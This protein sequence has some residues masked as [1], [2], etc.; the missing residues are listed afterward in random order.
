MSPSFEESTVWLIAADMISHEMRN[1]LNAM[2]Q[3]AEEASQSIKPY[4]DSD[5][6]RMPRDVAQENLDAVETI[7]FCGKH[8]KQIIDDVLTISKL[9]ANLLNLCPTATDPSAVAYNALQIYGS[10]MRSSGIRSMVTYRYGPVTDAVLLDSGRLLQVLINLI[11][12]SVKFMKGRPVKTLTI[13]ISTTRELLREPGIEYVSAT[14]AVKQAVHE[15][16]G[17]SQDTIYVRYSVTDTG[18]GLTQEEIRTVFGRFKQASPKTHAQ[19]GGSGLGLF[20][21]QQL[22]TLMGGE[23]GLASVPGEG[24]TFALYVRGRILTTKDDGGTTQSASSLPRSQA[25]TGTPRLQSRSH[26]ALRATPPP[27]GFGQSNNDQPISVLVVEDNLVNLNILVRQLKRA[28]FNTMTAEDG[29]Q[30]L[31]QI[32]K[33]TVDRGQAPGEVGGQDISLVLCDLEMPVMDGLT[34]VRHVREM[35][36]QGLIAHAMP[37][38]LR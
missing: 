9:D 11:G 24:S 27:K 34:C 21:C 16:D 20:I 36:G 35:Q 38:T 15:N 5:E 31:E 37:S 32:R 7:L 23:I 17:G 6:C 12:N 29:Q 4:A 28:G 3:C 13:D 25:M 18:P 22:L 2:L 26:D 14:Q 33:S 30:A 8:Q 19:Y 10:E 1:P